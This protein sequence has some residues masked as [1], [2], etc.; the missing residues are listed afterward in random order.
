MFLPGEPQGR[1]SL[2]GC[3]LWGRPELDT[4]EAA[5]AAA[6]AVPCALTAEDGVN[7]RQIGHHVQRVGTQP[8]DLDHSA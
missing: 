5:A 3:R 1:G 7:G 4:T 2:V 8:F 6:A